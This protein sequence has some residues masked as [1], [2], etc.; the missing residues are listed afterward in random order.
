VLLGHQKEAALAELYGNA[1]V[2]VL[3]STH[4]GQP[5][6]VI[7]ALGYG[8]PVILSDIPAHQEL[9]LAMPRFFPAGDTTLL[10][11]RLRTVFRDP[12][13]RNAHTA[14]RDRILKR[15]DWQ[16]IARHTLDVYRVALPPRRSAGLRLG[17]KD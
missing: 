9:G 10:A 7:E 13:D 8:C 17:L 1:G 15:H 16:T 3:P 14:D 2:F 5:I 12:P 11:E 6:A 4:E